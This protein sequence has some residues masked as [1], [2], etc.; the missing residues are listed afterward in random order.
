MHRYLCNDT[1]MVLPEGNMEI[2]EQK[3]ILIIYLA[4]FTDGVPAPAVAWN[5][6]AG[7]EAGGLANS[8]AFAPRGQ[9]G[10]SNLDHPAGAP[11]GEDGRDWGRRPLLINPRGRRVIHNGE[12]G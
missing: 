10:G 2:A 8:G 6:H 4:A 11:G 7:G 1:E 5:Q 9:R 12:N 3:S